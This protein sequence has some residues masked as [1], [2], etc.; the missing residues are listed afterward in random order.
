MSD[1][2]AAGNE[3][4]W[5]EESDSGVRFLC[6]HGPVHGAMNELDCVINSRQRVDLTRR[7]IRVAQH[8]RILLDAFTQAVVASQDCC[9][10]GRLTPQFVRVAA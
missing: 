4:S 2:I 9:Y 6:N 3:P 10:S 7:V 8:V 1:A 5:D